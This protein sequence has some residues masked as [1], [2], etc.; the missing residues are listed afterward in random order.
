MTTIASQLPA[1]LYQLL[2]LAVQSVKASLF[3]LGEFIEFLDGHH[4][5][6]TVTSSLLP[7]LHLV[8]NRGIATGV[9]QGELSSSL[10]R[11]IGLIRWQNLIGTTDIV[12]RR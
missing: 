3:E 6:A 11:W 12:Y 1:L 5:L 9:S 10:H 4:A 8:V 2:A 7:A